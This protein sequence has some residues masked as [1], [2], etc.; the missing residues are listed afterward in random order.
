MI[1]TSSTTAVRHLTLTT[2]DLS[3][4]AQVLTAA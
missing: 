3:D 4:L 1:P 2:H